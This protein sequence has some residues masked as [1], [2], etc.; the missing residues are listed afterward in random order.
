MCGRCPGNGV[1]LNSYVIQPLLNLSPAPSFVRRL[2]CGTCGGKDLP[3]GACS[4]VS[5]RL[6]GA[7][8]WQMCY[9]RDLC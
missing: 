6:P 1:E 5:P 9:R 2:H 8:P 3:C 7:H 4:T